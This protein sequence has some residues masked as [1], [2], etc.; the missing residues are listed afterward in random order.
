MRDAVEETTSE[1]ST[2]ASLVAS[3]V[4]YRELP[5]DMIFLGTG[6]EKRGKA[7]SQS[8]RAQGGGFIER[9]SFNIENYIVR[10]YE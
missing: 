9:K 3:G 4:P 1:V 2:A 6:L 10:L 5:G 7:R 8:L